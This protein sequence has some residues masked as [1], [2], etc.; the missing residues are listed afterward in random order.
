MHEVINMTA[1]E[2][3]KSSADAT[4]K[5]LEAKWGK[6]LISAGFTALPD[7]NRPGN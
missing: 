7:V 3:P 2:K 4:D 5:I 6:T 1:K